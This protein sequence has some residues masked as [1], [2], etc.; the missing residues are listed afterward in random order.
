MAK[1][2]LAHQGVFFTPFA[3]PEKGRQPKQGSANKREQTESAHSRQKRGQTGKQHQ[4]AI[5]AQHHRVTVQGLA[6]WRPQT[7]APLKLNTVLTMELAKAM[8]LMP[9]TTPR[10]SLN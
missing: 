4:F 1:P 2:D 6:D 5:P 3:E 8:K 9:K 7:I 10:S